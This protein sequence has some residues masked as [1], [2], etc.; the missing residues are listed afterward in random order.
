MPVVSMSRVAALAIL[1]ASPAAAAG[2]SVTYLEAIAAYTNG[3][4]QVAIAALATMSQ[5]E[6][7]AQA[8]GFF[9]QRIEKAPLWLP[10]ARAA[11]MMH[12]EAWFDGGDLAVR[13]MPN[14]HYDAARAIVRA[15]DRVRIEGG[16][17]KGD[18]L[19]V[20]D[21]Y[22]L[23]VSHLHGRGAVAMSRGVL[24]EARRLFPTDPEVLLASGADHEMVSI[25]SAGY[26]NRYDPEGG[27][28]GSEK[29]VKER[30]LESAARYFRQALPFHEARVRLGH[31]LFR[32][33]QLAAAAEELETARREAVQP[34]LR[35]LANLFLG[36]IETGRDHRA[37]AIELLGEAL[38]MYPAGQ[39]AQLAMSE[40]AYLDGRLTDA[41]SLVTKVLRTNDKRDPWW[42]YLSGEFW[43][44][45]YRLAALRKAVRP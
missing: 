35:Y 40:A 9:D 24:A 15:I 25:V 28:T 20:R 34:Q 29:V 14:V 6:I 1:F 42:N 37:R 10:R 38:Q 8:T 36:L 12:T 17:V 26:L 23:T 45:E 5:R 30:E 2:Q 27:R 4:R 3:N 19:F 33:G 7:S 43:H 44:F 21:W 11:L 32:Q 13:M 22:L 18:P 41:A 39:A 16:P 31:V